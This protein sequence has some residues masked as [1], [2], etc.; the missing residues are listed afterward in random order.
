M[1]KLEE[2]LYFFIFYFGW[3]LTHF[4]KH[5]QITLF[6]LRQILFFLGGGGGVLCPSLQSLSSE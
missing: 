2:P 6:G 5:K 1:G 3:L 4:H